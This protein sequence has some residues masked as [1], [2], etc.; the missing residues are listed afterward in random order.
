MLLAVHT[1]THTHSPTQ[2]VKDLVNQAYLR[3]RD[4]LEKHTEQ[5]EK[6]AAS[7]LEK[8]V[9]NY[10]DLVDLIG[11]MAHEKRLHQHSELAEMWTNR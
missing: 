1:H 11:P 4:I 10:K 5:L 9:V 2:E 7:L 6:V 8:E 3:A